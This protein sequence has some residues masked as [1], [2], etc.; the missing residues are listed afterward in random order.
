MLTGYKNVSRHKN[1]SRDNLMLARIQNVSQIPT[2]ML[3]RYQNTRQIPKY[4][5][6]TKI[7]P[8]YQNT[9]WIPKFYLDTKIIPGYQHAGYN[10]VKQ[11]LYG[12]VH[13]IEIVLSILPLLIISKLPDNTILALYLAVNVDSMHY[14]LNY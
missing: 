8:A 6:D 4:Q 13:Y 3:A 1:I 11:I 7:L 9:S 14:Q 5:R 2:K 12:Y 10:I